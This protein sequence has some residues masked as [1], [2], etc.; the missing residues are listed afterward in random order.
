MARFLRFLRL[1]RVFKL[2]QI[3]YRLEELVM[4]ETLIATLNLLKVVS[5][6]IFIGH[7]IGSIFFVI[8]SG[9]CADYGNDC[10]LN[11]I[12]ILDKPVE[13]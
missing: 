13:A 8:G 5:I 6:V 1:L 12:G 9:E 11:N 4:N 7:W 2:K 10:W 3:L